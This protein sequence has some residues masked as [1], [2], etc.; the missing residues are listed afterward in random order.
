MQSSFISNN[1]IPFLL[2]KK[3]GE[4]CNSSTEACEKGRCTD[5][6]CKC[7]DDSKDDDDLCGSKYMAYV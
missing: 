3:V 2:E 5:N 7:S 1:C 6:V 4:A